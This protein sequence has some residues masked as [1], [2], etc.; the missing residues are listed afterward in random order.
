MGE[1]AEREGDHGRK[2]QARGRYKKGPRQGA[3]ERLVEANL[4]SETVDARY[5]GLL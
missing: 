5:L 3:H 2:G 1:G 4:S